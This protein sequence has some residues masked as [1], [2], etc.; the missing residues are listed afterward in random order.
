[1]LWH[2]L[3]GSSSNE[4]SLPKADL[5]SI[6]DHTGRLL[7][8]ES[9][10]S[11]HMTSVSCTVLKVNRNDIVLALTVADGMPQAE[12]AVILEVAQQ[13]AMLQCFTTVRE[14]GPGPRVTLRTPGRP[15]VLQRR[16][17]P[18]IDLFLG[19]TLCTPDR[20]VEQVPAQMINLSLEGAACVLVEPVS[21]GA[22]LTLNLTA[23]GLHPA[24]AEAA[25]VRCTPT[26]SHLWVVGVK[27]LG[28][29]PE[30]ELYLGKYIS[31]VTQSHTR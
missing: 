7:F 24:E 21:P 25:V 8:A 31:D 14:H 5:R 6:I 28:L 30:Q 9:T 17:F 16:R 23:V 15:H 13:T 27:F 20:P 10:S 18:R 1:V 19:I 26:P 4:T 3:K 29:R 22:T 11:N 2:R 12:T